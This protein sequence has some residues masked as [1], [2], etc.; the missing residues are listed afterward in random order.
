MT[1]IVAQLR[2]SAGN[3]PA[4]PAQALHIV[5]RRH[6]RIVIR[7]PVEGDALSALDY[8]VYG[9]QGVIQIDTYRI[10]FG[11]CKH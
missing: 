6:P 2:K 3:P 4:D 7:Q 8:L 1:Q 9:P 11:V 10:D 5:L